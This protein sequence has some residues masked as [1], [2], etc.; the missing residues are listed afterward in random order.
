MSTTEP[1]SR[2]F[3][4]VRT[5]APPFPGFT[6][7]NSTMRQT[8]LSSWMCIPFLNWFVLTVSAIRRADYRTVTSSFGN[9]VST[10]QPSSVTMTRSSIRTPATPL[11]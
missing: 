3:S 9:E 10:S 6:C 4:F 11:R 2:F 1:E 5:K 7:W 8:L